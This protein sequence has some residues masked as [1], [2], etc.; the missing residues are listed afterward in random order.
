MTI[1]LR[2]PATPPLS[3]ARIPDDEFARQRRA[4]LARW[5][6]GAEVDLDAAAAYHRALPR[7]KHLGWAM[8]EAVRRG[9]CLTQPRGGFGTFDLHID[10]MRV[11]EKDGLADIVPTTTDSYTRNER[12]AQA[13]RGW[14]DSIAAGRSLLNGFPIVNAGVAMCRRLVEAVDR[15]TIVLS[16]TAMPRLTSEIA[17]A[18]GFTGY[19]GSAIAYTLS[20]TKDTTLEEGI[21]NYQYLDRLT[22]EYAKRGVDLHRRQPGFLTGTNVPPSIALA[23]YVLDAL[24]AAAQ[25]VRNYGYELAQCLHL[26]QDAAALRVGEEIVQGYLRAAGHEGVF[27]PATSLHWMGAWPADEAQSAA[28]VVY[29]GM[30]AA[31]GKAASVTTKS[32]HEAIGIPTSQANAEG[33]RMTRQAIYMA[34]GMDLEGTASFEFEKDLIRRETRAIVDKVLEMGDGDAAAGTVR[35]AEAGVLDIP[36]SPNR[37]VRSRIMPA[38]DVD[39]ALRILDPA[40]VPI[41]KDVMEVHRERLRKRAERQGVAFDEGLAVSSVYELGEPL[42]RLMPFALARA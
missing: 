17:L 5:P 10:L 14:E 8:R 25:G 21:R 7:H 37:H 40:G 31:A 19:L 4:N 13:G 3:Q 16:G 39:G 36:W 20:Y 27:T 38:R 6:T 29:G 33:L 2:E 24:L 32:T 34:R 18:A 12:F 23:V 41:P 9:L 15:P 28:L 35:A 22:D 42:E 30:L 1:L 26:A 11:L